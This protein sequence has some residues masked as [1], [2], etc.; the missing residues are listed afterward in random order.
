MGTEQTEAEKNVN[1]L[2]PLTPEQEQQFC[3][4]MKIGIYKEL[5]KKGLLTDAQLNRLIS[6]QYK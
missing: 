2:I 3:V 6:M 4:S 1:N 5:H